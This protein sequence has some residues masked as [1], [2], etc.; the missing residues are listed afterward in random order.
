MPKATYK[1][2]LFQQWGTIKEHLGGSHGAFISGGRTPQRVDLRTTSLE[3]MV[4]GQARAGE[5]RSRALQEEEGGKARRCCGS[6]TAGSMKPEGQAT[7][8]GLWV[9]GADG[10]LLCGYQHHH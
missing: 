10:E 7:P 6:D 1:A 8:F 2:Q 4:I 9:E 5:S 3:A